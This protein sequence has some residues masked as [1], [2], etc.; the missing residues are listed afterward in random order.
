MGILC[1]LACLQGGGQSVCRGTEGCGEGT[2]PIRFPWCLPLRTRV[3]VPMVSA[4]E[5]P[6]WIP[7]LLQVFAL[8][9]HCPG[10]QL[11]PEPSKP[12]FVQWPHPHE[13]SGSVL[14]LSRVHYSGRVLRR[15]FSCHVCTDDIIP[16]QSGLVWGPTQSCGCPQRLGFI[17][18]LELEGKGHIL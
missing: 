8:Q 16:A 13:E 17:V 15:L 6:G 14:F 4:V 7:F 1:I 12:H 2:V 5:D 18:D 11:S 3:Q 9:R 10:S